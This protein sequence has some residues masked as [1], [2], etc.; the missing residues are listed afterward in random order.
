MLACLS[1]KWSVDDPRAC[2]GVVLSRAV[3]ILR[4]IETQPLTGRFVHYV[5]QS[6]VSRKRREK[7]GEKKLIHCINTISWL[8]MSHGYWYSV[9]IFFIKSTLIYL[10]QCRYTSE[11]SKKEREKE[12]KERKRKKEEKGK[13]KRKKER[14]ERGVRGKEDENSL[15]FS[16]SSHELIFS[17][18]SLS[19]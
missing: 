2:Q 11:V 5:E 19:F 3:I 9:S 12:E 1:I 16:L 8:I 6:S 15:S 14:V 4:S 17:F 7:N 13:R 18:S 10:L